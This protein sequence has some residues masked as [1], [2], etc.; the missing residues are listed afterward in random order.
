MS[1]LDE[2]NKSRKLNDS[3]AYGNL[4]L[5]LQF[6]PKRPK[7]TVDAMFAAQEASVN[8]L[9]IGQG[10]LNNQI[11]GPMGGPPGQGQ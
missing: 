4:S 1:T 2:L 11:G 5:A 7:A 8:K 9:K 3:Q 6:M 10:P